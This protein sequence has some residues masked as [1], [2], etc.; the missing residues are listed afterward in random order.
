MVR[1][2]GKTKQGAGCKNQ[3]LEG[4]RYCRLHQP[5][6][7]ASDRSGFSERDKDG[8]WVSD[9]AMVSTIGGATIGAIFGGPLGA[10][11]GGAIGAYMGGYHGKG[12]DDA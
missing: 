5:R 1:C 11:V 7:A 8:K 9:Q 6:R 4:A 12:D 3:A 2:Q 10:L